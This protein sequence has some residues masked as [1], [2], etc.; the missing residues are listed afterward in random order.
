M[1][2]AKEARVKADEYKKD[3]IE[4]LDT[5]VRND[6][7]NELA[8]KAIFSIIERLSGYGR[9]S[10]LSRDDEF[11]WQIKEAVQAKGFKTEVII[12]EGLLISWEN[13]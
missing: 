13:K 11:E 3:K 9:T 4:V 8:I 6:V 5:R 12:N 10:Y 2:T 7:G 1:I